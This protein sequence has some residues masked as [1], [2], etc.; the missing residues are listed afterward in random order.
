MKLIATHNS[1]TGEP[2]KNWFYRLMT[3]VAKCQVFNI[4]EQQREGC[5]Y[6]DLRVRECDDEG[7]YRL[8]HGLWKSKTTLHE[9]LQ[10]LTE[11][12]YKDDKPIVTIFYEGSLDDEE[13]E[14]W[15][16]ADMMRYKKEYPNVEVAI[17]G[18]KKPVWHNLVVYKDIPIRSDFAKITGWKALIPIP[19]LHWCFRHEPAFNN[20][21]YTMVDFL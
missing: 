2:S 10:L 11:V 15:F 16:L 17:V 6:F 21:V 3:P 18:V 4:E 19:F 5:R 7:H 8:C 20:D 1:G 14:Q 12:S 9:A 13:H